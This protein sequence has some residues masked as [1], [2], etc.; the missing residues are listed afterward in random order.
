MD[1]EE[2][3]AL[4]VVILTTVGM[5][6]GS[7][8]YQHLKTDKQTISI[9]ARSP[10]AGNWYPPEIILKQHRLVI[11]KIKNIDGVSHGFTLPAFNI[12]IDQIKAGET[13]QVT[14][15]PDRTGSYNFYCTVWC[16]PEHMR[17]VGT[18]KIVP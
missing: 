15:I 18:V 5:G 3:L 1:R 17:M 9:L 2:F 14:F 8:W 4:A 11:L 13:A 16:S 6:M 12:R 7:L 10:E